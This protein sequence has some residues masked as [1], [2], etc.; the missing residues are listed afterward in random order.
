AKLKDFNFARTF[1][2][3]E[4]TIGGGRMS[5]LPVQYVLQAPTLAKLEEVLPNFMDEVRQSPVFAMSDV[6]LKFNKPV[7]LVCN[8]EVKNIPIKINRF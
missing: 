1:V 8:R 4:Q 6:N 7:C 5:G 2:V 3:Q